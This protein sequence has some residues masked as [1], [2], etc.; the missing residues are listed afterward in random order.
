[1]AK[2]VQDAYIVAATRTPV[3]KAPRG[4]FRTARPDTLLAHV[5][6][7]AAAAV[8][9][10]ADVERVRGA[11]FRVARGALYGGR[12]VPAAAAAAA[13]RALAVLV[14]ARVEGVDSGAAAAVAEGE[15]AVA[16][17]VAACQ[18]AC[19]LRRRRWP[20][21]GWPGCRLRA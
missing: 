7:R 9:S 14:G 19:R 8:P 6:A 16:A 4:M 18:H 17:A 13:P 10:V 21:L 5:L 3:G 12:G 20:A 15:R 2:Q 11:I 1:M